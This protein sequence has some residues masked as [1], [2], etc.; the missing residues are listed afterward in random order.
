MERRWVPLQ[1]GYSKNRY[2]HFTPDVPKQSIM[3]EQFEHVLQ[4]VHRLNRAEQLALIELIALL[5]GEDEQEKI[6]EEVIEENRRRLAAYDLG[7]TEGIPCQEAMNQVR[8]RLKV[9]KLENL[10]NQLQQRGTFK[11]IEDPLDW[12]RRLRDEW[13]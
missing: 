5:L 1:L 8:E 2:L 4:Q 3:S 10:L 7:E 11:D 13:R 12:Q 9:K 6:P